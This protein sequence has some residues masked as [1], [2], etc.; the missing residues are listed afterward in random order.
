MKVIQSKKHYWQEEMISI[1]TEPERQKELDNK[2][3]IHVLTDS[4][5]AVYHQEYKN[6]K[7]QWA[8]GQS[9]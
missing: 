8:P 5:K 9:H 2:D 3:E 4:V 1:A 7:S 6:D